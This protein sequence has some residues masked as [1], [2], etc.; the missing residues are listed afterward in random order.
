M[1]HARKLL[2]TDRLVLKAPD[3]ADATAVVDFYARNAAHFARW[4]PPLPEDHATTERVR[5]ALAVCAEAFA[6]GNSLRWW[7]HPV[8]M[9][10]R[11]IGS[12]HC[13]TLVRGAF[14]SANLGYALDGGWQGHGLMDEALRAVI[15]EVFSPRV[16]LH[17]L[18]AGIQPDNQRSL[19]VVRRLG[20]SDIGL[21]RRYLY[22]A[23]AWRDH[24]LYEHLNPEFIAPDAW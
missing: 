9:P 22:I 5:Q 20:F 13:S 4:N 10:A 23:G 14:H 3:S 16:N 17:R 21:A 24:L 7:L 1:D 6:L 15:A 11:V 2:R 12:V 19:A 18:Q 8:R